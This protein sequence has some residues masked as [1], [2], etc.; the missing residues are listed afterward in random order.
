[1]IS[2]WIKP[3]YRIESESYREFLPPDD[4]GPCDSMPEEFKEVLKKP[5]IPDNPL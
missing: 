3:E 1:L 2:S 5:K 4:D